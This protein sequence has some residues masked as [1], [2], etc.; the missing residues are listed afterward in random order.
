MSLGF[1]CGASGKEPACQCSGCKSQG[2]DPGVGEM[3]WRRAPP[4]A[5]LFSPGEPHGQRSL[6]GFSPQGHSVG[7]RWSARAH[8]CIPVPTPSWAA[9]SPR[10]PCQ[11]S[12]SSR[13]AGIVP[14]ALQ[15][16][17]ASTYPPPG[18]VC[19]GMAMLLSPAAPPPLPPLGLQVRVLHP[20][21]VLALQISPSASSF[22]IQCICVNVWYLLFSLDWLRSGWQALSSSTSLKQ[23]QILPFYG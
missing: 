19:T 20:A 2:F 12:R 14:D 16:L 3:P 5:P 10:P 21:S 22:K 18:G 13:S 8:A 15:P 4:P 11:P 7:P 9:L 23:T 6:A 1:P 17:P